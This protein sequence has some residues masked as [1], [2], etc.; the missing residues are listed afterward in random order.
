MH[1]LTLT[2]GE[3]LTVEWNWGNTLLSPRGLIFH[4]LGNKGVSVQCEDFR[5]KPPPA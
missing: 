1:V 3:R 5:A 4:H 2:S